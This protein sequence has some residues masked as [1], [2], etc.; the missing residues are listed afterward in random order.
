M[1]ISFSRI[2][3]LFGAFTLLFVL[4][5]RV[6]ATSFANLAAIAIPGSGTEGIANPYP[7]I[8]NVSGLTGLITDVNVTFNGLSHTSPDN[9]DILLVGPGGQKMILMSD[10]GGPHN[11]SDLTMTFDDEAL[12]FPSNGSALL[13]G[14]FKPVNYTGNG[15]PNDVFPDPAPA[16][17][18]ASLLSIFDG[19]GPNGDWRLF[20]FDDQ[21]VSNDPGSGSIARG[22]SLDIATAAVPEPSTLVLLG[23]GLVAIVA[24]KRNIKS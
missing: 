21:G 19:T 13:S 24:R 18:Y 5:Q 16:G 4:T 3:G 17:P 15:G 12:S 2:L 7:S 14:S 20:V 9:I 1:T 8:I 10:A 11:V 23:A 22:W 6:Q